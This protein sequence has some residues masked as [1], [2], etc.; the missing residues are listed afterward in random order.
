MKKYTRK[1]IQFFWKHIKRYKWRFAVMVAGMTVGIGINMY[2][3]LIYK[4]FYNILVGTGSKE[5]IASKLIGLILLIM[6]LDL[7]NQIFWR[8][9]SFI[10]NRFQPKI[11]TNIQNECF[12]H[13]H[14]HSFNFFNNNFTG[15]LVKKS[16]RLSRSFEAVID[17]LYWDSYPIIL[18]ILIVFIVLS[19]VNPLL[20]GIILFWS[21]FFIIASYLISRLKIKYDE[22]RTKADTKVT[23]GLADTITNATN[24]KLFAGLRYEINKFYEITK[25]WRQSMKKAWD[26][27]SLIDGMQGIMM[28]LLE[29]TMFY[30]AIRL[31]TQNLLTIGD[32]VLIQA[33]LLEIFIHLWGIGRIIRGLYSDFADAEEMIEILNTPIEIKDAKNAKNLTVNHGSVEFKNV[34]FAYENGQNVIDNLSFKVKPSEKIAL[35]GPSG[36]GKT[37]MT[38]LIL[39]LFDIQKG[40]IRIDGR[41]IKTATQ[42]SLRRNLSLVP[43]DPILFHRTLMENIRY[44][45]RDASDEEVK[46]AA[47]MANCHE[48]IQKFK[49]GYHTYVGERGVKLSGG[50][51]QRVAIARAILSNAKILILDE[52]T[53]QL[54][55]ESEKLI[56]EALDNLMKNK[57][58]FIVA[59]RL[60][61]IMK[62]DRIF[63]IKDGRIIEEGR[64]ANLINKKDSLYKRLW[65][66][67][68]GGYLKE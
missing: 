28:I 49:K 59:H 14:K 60:S 65:D 11:I 45:R 51:R 58:T 26:I 64:H 35:I 21:V 42:D 48:F 20:G 50:E 38:K 4:Q 5:E 67:Q 37:T 39:R 17:R 32:F 40:E 52:A 16:L 15:G 9:S 10:N 30:I 55:S 22:R 25:E 53:S 68:V 66:L 62:A 7:I 8:I 57:T 44:G 3:P 18:R 23:A 56:Q 46:A 33:Y 12:E 24:I 54:D 41:D 47:K 36:G 13:L 19:F 31:W 61:T 43:Q 34:S 1:T 63:V 27:D 6:I 2:F 29:F